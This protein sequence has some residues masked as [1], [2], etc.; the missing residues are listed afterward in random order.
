MLQLGV[1]GSLLA[2]EL[3]GGVMHSELLNV[4]LF[5]SVIARV[6]LATGLGPA[7]AIAILIE[8]FG[9]GAL[10]PGQSES[11][12]IRGSN[13]RFVSD[14]FLASSKNSGGGQ[15]ALLSDEKNRTSKSWA[16]SPP[17][18]VRSA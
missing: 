7:I 13:L 2:S 16:T 5:A 12:H 4:W 17:R 6:L 3:G 9:T 14:F 18:K 8:K 10:R 1:G 15:L 11:G